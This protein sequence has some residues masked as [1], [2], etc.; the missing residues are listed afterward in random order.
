MQ[1]RENLRELSCCTDRDLSDLG[2][3]RDDIRRV[4]QEAAFV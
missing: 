2:I 1:Y 3:S 4:A